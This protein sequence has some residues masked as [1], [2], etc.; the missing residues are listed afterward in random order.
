MVLFLLTVP[1]T[2][3]KVPQT[4]Q[5]ETAPSR[6]SHQSPLSQ[7]LTKAASPARAA[8]IYLS[9]EHVYEAPRADLHLVYEAA[10]REKP[11][12]RDL[13]RLMRLWCHQ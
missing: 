2:H 3:L 6:R 4:L 12:G 13:A 5:L 9:F 10:P 8:G 7:W 1:Y 11:R